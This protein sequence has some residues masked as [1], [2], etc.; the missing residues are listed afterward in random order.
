MFLLIAL[1]LC[2]LLSAGTG[3]I[4]TVAGTGTNG[5]TAPGGLALNTN[6]N[7][8][9]G[10]ATDAS[11]NLFIADGGNN[12]VIRVDSSTGI[13][14]LV[15]GN[16]S[17]SSTGNGGPA[18][19][20]AVN[21]PTGVALDAAGNLYISE[22]L[23]NRV[24]RVD[25]QTGIITTIA[26]TGASA[27]GGDYGPAT[28]AALKMPHGI[29][30]DSAGNLYIADTGNE[31]IR[32]V[33]ALTG[34]IVTVAGTGYNAA[35]SDG[36]PADLTSLSM[37]SSVAFDLSG[38]L[39]I[40]EA[41]GSRIRR[42]NPQTGIVS[43]VA[44]NGTADFS[45]DGGA[46]TSAGIG[47][48]WGLAVDSSGSIFFSDGGS[49]IRRVDSVTGLISTVAG[50]GT[51]HQ[52]M[53]LGGGG[54][55]WCYGPPTGDNGPA[56]NATLDG[57]VA[58]ALTGGDLL[59]SDWIA[60]VVRRVSLP[61][62]YPY[63]LTALTASTTSPHSGQGVLLTATVTPMGASGVPTGSVVFAAGLFSEQVLGTATL[64]GGTASLV[65]STLGQGTDPIAAYYSGDASYN[66]SGSPRLSISVSGT[67]APTPAIS[68]SANQNSAVA[69]VPFIFTA[70]VAPPSGST[71][72]PSGPVVLYDGSTLV[73]TASLVNGI[74]S[75]T[76][77]F[78]TAGTHTLRA[79]YLGD[80]N[81][82]QVASAAVSVLVK[83]AAS[84]NLSL[85]SDPSGTPVQLLAQVTPSSATGTVQW[86]DGTSL[87][88]T[89]PVQSGAAVFPYSSLAP[90]SHS[91]QVVYS[92]DASYA[93]SNSNVLPVIVPFQT[94]ISL[95]PL[96]PFTFGQP[97]TFTVSVSPSTAT[98]T[99]SLSGDGY[100]IGVATL[101][102]GQASV[103]PPCCLV[104]GSRTLFVAYSGDSAHAATNASFSIQIAKAAAN[105]LMASSIN[106]STVGQIPML[107]ATVTPAG[108]TGS[109]Q[110]FDGSTLM[111]TATLTNGTTTFYPMA[112]S[113][114]PHS[115]TA[116]Y[117]GD[118]N[119][120]A[121]TS[122][123]ITQV[124]NKAVSG[125]AIASSANP[126]SFGQSV[127][128]TA[129]VSPVSATGTVR[130][131]D[132]TTSFGTATLASGS[133]AL[134]LSTLASGVHSI[135]AAYSGSNNYAGSTS[136]A[137]SQT[138][139][140]APPSKLT[141]SAASSSK[142]NLAWTASSTSGV[143]YNVYSSTT[144][145]FTPS[146]ANRIA[147]GL[148]AASYSNTGLPASSTRYYLVTAQNSAGES[149]A[150]NQA[151]AATTAALSCH[152]AYSVT[153]QW[154][155][156]FGGALT[157]Q[158]TGKT[159]ISGWN[160]TWTWPGNQQITES[161]DAT[162]TQK[163][164]NATLTNASYDA[165]IAAGATISGI[166]FNASYSGAN[167]APS[168]FYVNGTLCK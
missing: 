158:N 13:L 67:T 151:S 53:C 161:W 98:G 103:T 141:A 162:Y 91:I 15:A 45:G 62:P 108:L 152:V 60:S 107:T 101:S 111:G 112:F 89:S 113:P 147:L 149:A 55:G 47:M 11:G 140:P 120:T 20:A 133:A 117:N 23:G 42:V 28:V 9:A 138:V 128:F 21:T 102:G 51:G 44:G 26:G 76:T 130:F 65:S 136:A 106:P 5:N 2:P 24:R 61:S 92:G 90:G 97:L 17:A 123:V 39:L 96:G 34:I 155:T 29:A 156:G 77:V 100:P 37:P 49:R 99:V 95:T 27:F 52:S 105:V 35:V 1:A 74:A 16:G 66:G 164:A 159:A 78:L 126:S 75:I 48:P 163:G 132:G 58:V 18:T 134:T 127:T 64:N 83:G 124:V 46:A 40:G 63:T 119:S 85:V 73:G 153:G 142:I 10:I 167:T 33:Y 6:L 115:L 69:G 122:P 32:C 82:S 50:N 104:A 70:T 137:L 56:P 59:V 143:A 94:T 145:G 93:I 118:T 84:V 80:N 110:F 14:T 72:I 139:L 144:A 19:L 87:L 3:L 81:Y 116:V 157:I 150:S 154:N 54:G 165:T 146:A 125:V 109:V 8:P 166:G 7:E 30:L 43:T 86:V 79:T 148:T 22:M 57:P 4:V 88:G 71:S 25:A 135:I 36:L 131:L 114:G 129:T 121:G 12:R 31:R 41:G 160:L 38:G 68:L 168:A